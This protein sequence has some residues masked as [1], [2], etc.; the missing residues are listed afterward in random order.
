MSAYVQL[1]ST[2]SGSKNLFVGAEV[3]A[4]ASQ[5]APF[6]G[7]LRLVATRTVRPNNTNWI[8]RITQGT[9]IEEWSGQTTGDAVVVITLDDVFFIDGQ[10]ISITLENDEPLDTAVAVDASLFVPSESKLDSIVSSTTTLATEIGKVPRS[11][12]AVAAGQ[13]RLTIQGGE[14]ANITI[15]AP[16]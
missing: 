4:L 2:Q 7:V 6:A 9:S 3:F 14:G 5:S 8:V 15:G 10:A 1:G 11:E 12:S 13:Y 16:V